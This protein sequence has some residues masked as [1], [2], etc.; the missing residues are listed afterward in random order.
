M[1]AH[2][3][4]ELDKSAFPS[5]PHQKF[6]LWRYISKIES[7]RNDMWVSL[8]GI[9]AMIQL[10]CGHWLPNQGSNDSAAI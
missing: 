10:F 3:I 1:I 9:G 4:S 7:E 2:K 5:L 6:H 8:G